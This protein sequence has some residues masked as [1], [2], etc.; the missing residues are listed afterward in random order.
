MVGD[1]MKQILLALMVL[2]GAV[3]CSSK[4]AVDSFEGPLARLA[5][6]AGFYV[7]VPEDG[8]YGGKS[9]AGSGRAAAQAAVAALSGRADKVVQAEA[10]GRFAAAQEKAKAA[11]L[12]YIFETTILNWEDRATEWSGRPD[13][14]TLK[15]AVSEVAT[16]KV[17]ASTVARASSKWGT[18]G[19]DHP[20]DLLP[21]PRQQ[22]VDRLF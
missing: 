2:V 13:R 6:D 15:M 21:V 3:G 10:P 5:R 9:Y 7:M 4:H 20:Q 16:G 14:I 11:G 1:S 8:R 12:T 19:G 17:V 22:F 18:L